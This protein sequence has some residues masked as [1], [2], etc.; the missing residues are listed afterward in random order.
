MVYCRFL[1]NQCVD[2]RRLHEIWTQPF[3]RDFRWYKMI[4]YLDIPDIIETN[5]LNKTWFLNWMGPRVQ[6]RTVILWGNSWWSVVNQFWGPPY[7]MGMGWYDMVWLW[8]KIRICTIRGCNDK[9]Q[10]DP[11]QVPAPRIRQ[12]YGGRCSE[13]RG[14]NSVLAD[15]WSLLPQLRWSLFSAILRLLG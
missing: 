2:S 5:N 9:S 6:L 11:L 3:W 12:I 1:L 7:I 14:K 15:V 10:A 13:K 8:V 4:S